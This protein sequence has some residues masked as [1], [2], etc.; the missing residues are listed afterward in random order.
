MGKGG[1][2]GK[3]MG[4]WAMCRLAGARLE[5]YTCPI[6]FELWS[7]ARPEEEADLQQAL[8]FSHH[9]LFEAEDWR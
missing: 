7:G 6:R 1:I 4:R 8:G 5:A 9:I 3:I 2:F